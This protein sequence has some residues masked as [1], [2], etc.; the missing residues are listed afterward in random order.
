MSGIEEEA[1]HHAVPLAELRAIH[2]STDTMSSSKYPKARSIE[3]GAQPRQ[4]SP[5]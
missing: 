2:L 1:G 3:P 4:A 5:R